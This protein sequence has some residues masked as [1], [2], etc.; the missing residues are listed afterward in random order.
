MAIIFSLK[1]YI[2]TQSSRYSLSFTESFGKDKSLKD[3]FIPRPACSGHY[4]IDK[5]DV[6]KY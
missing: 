5:I 2:E 3:P 1:A 6:L 4:V